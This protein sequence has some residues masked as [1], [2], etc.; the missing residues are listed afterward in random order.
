MPRAR[1]FWLKPFRLHQWQ[2][3][4]WEHHARLISRANLRVL[5]NVLYR[6]VQDKEA[7]WNGVWEESDEGEWFEEGYPS[8]PVHEEGSAEKGRPLKM[9]AWKT[10]VSPSGGW[11]KDRP[12]HAKV[13]AEGR[14]HSNLPRSVGG[15]PI[16]P[17]DMN[18]EHFLGKQNLS[19]SPF[20]WVWALIDLVYY[21]GSGSILSCRQIQGDSE[22]M[23]PCWCTGVRARSER[24]D[25][26]RMRRGASRRWR[27]SSELCCRI[28][29]DLG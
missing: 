6:L 22:M 24:S 27:Q 17:H 16:Q 9:E 3:G 13:F 26:W 19:T 7:R 10:P 29:A 5:A 15:E 14:D 20:F 25:S 8:A 23:S 28:G 2:S 21:V 18:D 1:T 12:S 11:Y 4:S